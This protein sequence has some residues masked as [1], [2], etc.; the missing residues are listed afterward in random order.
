MKKIF[1]AIA[2]FMLAVPSMAQ[3]ASGGF[4]L[5]RSICIMVPAWD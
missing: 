5:D 4:E 3:F 2:A 1:A